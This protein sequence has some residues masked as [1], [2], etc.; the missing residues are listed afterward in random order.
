MPNPQKPGQKPVKPGEYEERGPR[1]G[2]IPN[3]KVVTM[4]PGDEKLPPT[5]EPGRTWVRVGKPKH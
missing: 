2:H 1:G 3:P 5:K 4:E